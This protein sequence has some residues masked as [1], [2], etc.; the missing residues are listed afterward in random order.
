VRLL[1]VEDEPV[2]AKLL[3]SNLTKQGF[4]VDVALSVADAE[5][6]LAAVRYD[7]VLLDLKLPDGDG[8]S[9]L[10]V[11]RA[12]GPVPVIAI[13]A[14]DGV[15]DRVQGLNAGADDYIVK[16][17]ALEELVARINAVLRRPGAGVDVKL[18]WGDL[19]LNVPT[20][21]LRV[22]GHS[23]P[24]TRREVTALELLLMAKGSIVPRARLIDG[25]YAFDD[26]PISNA[27]DA[28]LSRLRKRLREVSSRV[29]IRT[30]RGVGYRLICLPT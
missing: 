27:I 5:A 12:D 10:P 15:R 1:A 30:I 29:T 13:T 19:D 26:E 28:H 21:E 18:T 16:P 14:K 22:N 4:A 3:K 6:H 7:L 8:L 25:L 23:M 11:I 2:L 17:V 9:L 20:K 24:I